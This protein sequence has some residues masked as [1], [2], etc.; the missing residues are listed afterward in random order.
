[1]VHILGRTRPFLDLARV[2]A[3]RKRRDQIRHRPEVESLESLALMSSTVS[4]SLFGA[5]YAGPASS[6]PGL[7]LTLSNPSNK[8]AT[9]Q[10]LGANLSTEGGA[11]FVATD[12]SL[13]FDA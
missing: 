8:T 12:E 2:P 3:A 11:S 13:I 7:A 4:A 1:M 10:G 5:A 6:F 9:F